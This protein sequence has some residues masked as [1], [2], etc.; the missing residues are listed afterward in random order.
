MSV[1]LKHKGMLCFYEAEGIRTSH[2]FTTRLGGVSQGYLASMNI[3]TSRGDTRENVLE[4]YRILGENLGF[5]PHN[6]VLSRQ[7]HSDIVLKAEGKNRGAGLYADPMP[8]CDGLV[9]NEKGLALV[10]FTADCTPILFW[11]PVTGAVGAAHAGWRGTAKAIGARTVEAM[12][13][14]YGAKP[15]NIRAAIGPNIGRCHFETGEDVKEAMLAAFG[16]EARPFIKPFGEKFH[17]DLKGINEMVLK[18]AGVGH[19]D[20]SDVCTVCS[21]ELLWSHRIVGQQ[22][23]SQGAVIVCGEACK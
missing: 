8:D 1:I 22:R 10:I 21:P 9:T 20:V 14:Y 23:G 5:D 19:I 3:G 2:C 11:D 6:A 15:E 16:E 18:S 13:K 7:I 12:V 4:N 17:V